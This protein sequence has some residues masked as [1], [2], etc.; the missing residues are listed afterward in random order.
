VSSAMCVR[1]DSA[2]PDAFRHSFDTRKHALGSLPA[3]QLKIPT[4]TILV[5]ERLNIGQDWHLR[6]AELGLL[7]STTGQDKSPKD[8]VP[9]SLQLVVVECVRHT[10]DGLLPLS[11]P[12]GDITRTSFLRSTRIEL[13]SKLYRC[14]RVS[15]AETFWSLIRACHEFL[16]A[17][18]A[19]L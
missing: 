19:P 4:K 14:H 9:R 12:S 8:L 11:G 15:Y 6:A 5:I 17:E 2:S 18:R 7:L 13:R 3:H 10:M 16:E 1:R